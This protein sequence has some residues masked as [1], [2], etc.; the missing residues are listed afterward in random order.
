MAW[1]KRSLL[2]VK[3]ESANVIA[4]TIALKWLVSYETL[5]VMKFFKELALDI[6]SLRL[7]NI[8]LLKK[9]SLGIWNMFPWNILKQICK[10]VLH[11]L[12]NKW[13]E[14]KNG[15]RL[16]LLHASSLEN[17]KCK[18]KQGKMQVIYFGFF[19]H[20]IF[21]NIC[22][23]KCCFVIGNVNCGSDHVQETL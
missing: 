15:R 12:K 6:H 5:D 16:A 11:C 17:W 3:D 22:T 1:P 14:E 21:M 19:F 10:N 23:P 9:E 7:F 8:Q 18:S 4:M 13:K 2:Y 20:F